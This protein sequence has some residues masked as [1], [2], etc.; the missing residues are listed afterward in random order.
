MDVVSTAPRAARG[1]VLGQSWDWTA[2]AA[3]LGC[4]LRFAMGS[5]VIREAAEGLSIWRARQGGR[6]GLELWKG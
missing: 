5:V 4:Y 3:E 2:Q 6:S 1:S